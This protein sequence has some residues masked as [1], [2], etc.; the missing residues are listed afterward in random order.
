MGRQ[1]LL[2]GARPTSRAL[3]VDVDG[4]RGP[5]GP[6]AGRLAD[7]KVDLRKGFR[8]CNWRGNI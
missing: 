1:K 2:N 3:I 6:V 7:Q 4:L 5:L 8:C